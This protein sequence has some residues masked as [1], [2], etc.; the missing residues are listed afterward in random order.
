M[1]GKGEKKLNKRECVET[2][3]L[4]NIDSLYRYAYT[5]MKRKEEAEDVVSES[6][7][8]ALKAS[9]SLKQPEF[10]KTWVYKIVSNTALNH[11][12]RKNKVEVLSYEEMPDGGT[13]D[14]YSNLDFNGLINSLEVKYRSVIVL[15]FMEDMKI[16]DI[17]KILGINE[18]TV[19][20]RL[21]TALKMIKREMEGE[22]L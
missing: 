2:F 5:Y 15:R 12:K 11:I 20:T 7:E 9:K 10:V 3:I 14:D 22:V 18:N 16:G 8:K 17:S 21:Y 4:E 19:K 13:F 1:K 6:V